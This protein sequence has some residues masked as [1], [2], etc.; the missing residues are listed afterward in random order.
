MP[1]LFSLLTGNDIVN[2]VDYTTYLIFDVTTH[3]E[4]DNE[5]FNGASTTL[6]AT[7]VAVVAS[8]TVSLAVLADA[9]QTASTRA[10][11]DDATL[12]LTQVPEPSSALLVGLVGLGLLRRR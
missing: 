12:T 1:S 10:T 2:E 4:I 11:I 7:Y 3:V 6:N 9:A 8:T 5:T